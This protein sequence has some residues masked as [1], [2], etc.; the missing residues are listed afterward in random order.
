MDNHLDLIDTED[1]IKELQRRHDALVVLMIKEGLYPGQD[2]FKTNYSGGAH[3]CLGLLEDACL[4]MKQ[5]LIKAR[6]E[7][8]AEEDQS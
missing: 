3:T 5:E 1:L 6:D 8:E 4:C 7:W 2:G